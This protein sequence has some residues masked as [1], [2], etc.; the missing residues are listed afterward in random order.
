MSVVDELVA[1]RKAADR[2]Q[3][4]LADS[5]GLTRMTVQRMESKKLDPRLSTV[6]ELARALGMD[7]MLVPRNL[8][9][10]LEAFMRSGGKSLGQPPGAD[11]P[12]SVVDTINTPR[13]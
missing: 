7:L 9:P 11:A 10:D 6:L 3:E 2:T 4:D 13:R 1:T 12:P 8:R 5:A